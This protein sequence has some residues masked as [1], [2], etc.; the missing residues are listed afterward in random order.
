MNTMYEAIR[1]HFLSI[2]RAALG[3]PERRCGPERG[4]GARTVLKRRETARTA[5]AARRSSMPHGE[6]Q[7][8]VLQ[9]APR[10]E[11]AS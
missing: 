9:K 11:P 8:I 3:L 6:S 5:G 2:S 7:L 1:Q 10:R 4:E